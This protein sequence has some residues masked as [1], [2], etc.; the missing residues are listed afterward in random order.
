MMT[1]VAVDD[2]P[3]ALQLI[4][5]YIEE[6]PELSLL[7]K[8]IN[9]LEASA[10]LKDK[11]VDIV[12]VDVQMPDLNGIEF[13]RQLDSGPKVIFTTAYKKYAIEGFKLEET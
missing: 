1:I 4:A 2:E 7:G 5:G 12:M 3:L 10:F 9:P 13:T 11:S 8:F 6:T